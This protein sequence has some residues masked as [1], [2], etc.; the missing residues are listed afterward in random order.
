MKYGVIIGA[1]CVRKTNLIK[2][3]R[4]SA[5]KAADDYKGDIAHIY[6]RGESVERFHVGPTSMIHW[7]STEFLKEIAN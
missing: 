5:K 4:S 1:M 6:Y 3:A 7:Q 2:D